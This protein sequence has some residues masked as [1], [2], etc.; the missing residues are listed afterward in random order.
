MASAGAPLTIV[1]TTPVAQIFTLANRHGMRATITNYG[2]IVMALDVPDREGRL[3]DVVLGFDALE[4]YFG[5]H[6]FF[7]ALIGRYGNRIA[8]GRFRLDD[9]DYVLATNNGPNHLHGG[10]RGFD[11]VVWAAEL[12]V[13]NEG[14]SLRLSHRSEDGDEGYPGTLT[15][16]VTYTI[17]EN[18]E[19]RIDYIAA[20]DRA[21]VVNLTHHSYFNLAGHG[22]ILSHELFIDADAYTPVDAS[23]IPTGELRA[24]LGTPFDFREPRPIGGRVHDPDPQL[25]LANGYDHNFVLVPRNAG[26]R[27]AARIHEPRSG[28]IMEVLTTDPGLQLYTGNGLDGSLIGTKGLPIERHAGLCLETQHFPDSPNQPTFPSTRLNPGEEY[29]SQTVYRFSTAP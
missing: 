7:G 20:T 14:P 4:S 19:L 17:T 6:P 3:E 10:P 1:T 12:L 16:T 23:L 24:V 29:S 26:L 11:R 22:D 8:K 9:R 28:R 5:P 18:D 21:T 2:G 27:L 13:T 25:R 15:A